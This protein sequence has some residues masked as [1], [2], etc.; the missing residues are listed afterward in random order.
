MFNSAAN[1]LGAMGMGSGAGS[2][3]QNAFGSIATDA[4]VQM[5]DVANKYTYEASNQEANRRANAWDSG[6][7]RQLSLQQQ[8]SALQSDWWARMQQALMA[9]GSTGYMANWQNQNMPAANQY[10]QSMNPWL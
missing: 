2:P 1:R 4:S 8:N 10:Q 9:G 7:N 6:Q 5:A 3:A